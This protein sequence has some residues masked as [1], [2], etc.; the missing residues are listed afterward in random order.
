[1][2]GDILVLTGSENAFENADVIS[3]AQMR[4]VVYSHSLSAASATFKCERVKRRK[5]GRGFCVSL[6]VVS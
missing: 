5:R 3:S 6:A 1:M 2:H 4:V